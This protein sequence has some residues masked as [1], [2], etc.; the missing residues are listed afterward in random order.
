MH[1]GVTQHIGIR[2]TTMDKKIVNSNIFF[3]MIFDSNQRL[4]DPY[5]LHQLRWKGGK[6]MRL[7]LLWATGCLE[8]SLIFWFLLLAMMHLRTCG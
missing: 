4:K 7:R 3:I 2:D 6:S 5:S 8:A 1:F